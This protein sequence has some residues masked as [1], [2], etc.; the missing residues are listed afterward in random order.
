MKGIRQNMI[1]TVQVA[2]LLDDISELKLT[3]FWHLLLDQM[4]I[5]TTILLNAIALR[6]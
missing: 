5:S 3:R 1:N 2:F 4:L 6:V